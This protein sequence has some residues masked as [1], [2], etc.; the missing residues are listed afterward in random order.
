VTVAEFRSNGG[1]LGCEHIA[2]GA[3]LSVVRSS[4]LGGWDWLC[5]VSVTCL[6]SSAADRNYVHLRHTRPEGRRLNFDESFDMLQ[7]L[8][9]RHGKSSLGFPSS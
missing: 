9:V 2:V 8:D 6:A 3:F 1:R 5:F 4:T 7:C